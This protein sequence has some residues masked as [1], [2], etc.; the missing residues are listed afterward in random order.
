MKKI[1]VK[2]QSVY[3]DEVK[4]V[5]IDRA[6]LQRYILGSAY[7]AQDRMDNCPLRPGYN[8]FKIEFSQAFTWL[9]DY[10]RQHYHVEHGQPFLY[11]HE[12]YG[13]LLPPR[14]QTIKR[15]HSKEEN[16]ADYI[17]L[18][19]VDI[20]K[21]SCNLVI[22][23]ESDDLKLPS[24]IISFPL[25]DNHFHLFPASLDYYISTNTGNQINCVLTWEG[26]LR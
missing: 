24:Q 15:N 12:W 13:T 3:T 19:G 5:V 1:L 26:V 14:E 11:A 22:E 17:L 23:Y 2:E 6:E 8:N 18:Y 20:E 7:I 10:V 4:H 16:P 25:Q 9:V 21:N